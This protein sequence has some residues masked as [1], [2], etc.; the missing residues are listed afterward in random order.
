MAFPTDT[1]EYIVNAT[2][3]N[4]CA[5]SDTVSVIVNPLP[6]AFAGNDV[7]ICFGDTTTLTATG[8]LN[9]SWS[10]TDS[11]SN[12]LN[13]ITQAFPI[14]TT[15][16]IVTVTDTNGCIQ[17]DSIVVTVNELPIGDAVADVTICN[18]DSAQL[19]ATGGDTYVWAPITGLSD[20]NIAD[21][22]A[23]SIVT[24]NYVVLITDLNGCT[25]T[26][27]VIVTVNNLPNISAGS[28]IQICIGDTT[29]L[30][31]TG[32]DQLFMD[33]RNGTFK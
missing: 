10:P 26:D 32:G 22:W 17:S 2:D 13:D 28:D 14:I 7:A 23:T 3:I 15:E 18:G 24:T 5:N 12:P 31:V 19:N 1:T 29:Q 33:S 9:Y 11:L 8:G 27:T 25:D 6:S 16:Y 20:P 4:G 30:L 21:P